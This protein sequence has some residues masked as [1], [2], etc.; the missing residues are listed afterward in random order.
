[1]YDLTLKAERARLVRDIGSDEN[2]ARK[3]ESFKQSEIY[4]GRLEQ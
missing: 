3:A 4:N 1:M 2:K